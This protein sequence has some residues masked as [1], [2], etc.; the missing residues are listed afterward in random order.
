MSALYIGTRVRVIEPALYR[1]AEGT[2]VEVLR[3]PL[4]RLYRVRLAGLGQLL[5]CAAR[6]VEVV[7]ETPLRKRAGRGE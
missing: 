2:V 6:E 5:T 4:G 7:E 3:L 1:G